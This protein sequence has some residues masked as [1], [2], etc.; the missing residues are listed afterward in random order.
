MKIRINKKKAVPN[1]KEYLKIL[2]SSL[3]VIYFVKTIILFF[4]P[5]FINLPD[6]WG[7]VIMVILIVYF[8]DIIELKIGGREF[9]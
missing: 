5:E 7:L 9:I 1:F 4:Y 6:F 8:K 3:F 2:A